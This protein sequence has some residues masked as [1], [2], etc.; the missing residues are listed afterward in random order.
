MII[1][2]IRKRKIRKAAYQGAIGMT[3]LSA[4]KS[5]AVLLDVEDADFEACQKML[6]EFFSAYG[7]SL[8]IFYT[9]FRKMSKDELLTTSVET[10]LTRHRLG[11]LGFPDNVFMNELGDCD[12]FINLSHNLCHAV[13]MISVAMPAS[14]KLGVE[15]FPESQYCMVIRSKENKEEPVLRIGDYNSKATLSTI[16]DFLKKI[17]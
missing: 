1:S 11:L 17:V 5:A 8:R 13:R 14:F 3:P 7:I 6:S 15:D 2:Y 4:I 10:T 12:L 16:F 9:D